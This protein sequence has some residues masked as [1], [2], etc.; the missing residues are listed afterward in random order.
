MVGGATPFLKK[1]HREASGPPAKTFIKRGLSNHLSP[2]TP[3]HYR[4]SSVFPPSLFMPL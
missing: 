1:L 4:M 2:P 3:V